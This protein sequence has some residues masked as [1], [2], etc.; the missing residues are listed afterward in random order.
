MKIAVGV[1]TDEQQRIFITQRPA[2]A[3]HAGFWEFPGGKLE[4]GEC[5]HDAL[6]RE[7]QEEI[8]I[9]VTDCVF[10]GE[11]EHRYATHAVMIY[12]YHVRDYVGSVSC[13]EQQPAFCWVK[14]EEL[15]QYLFPEA[16]HKIIDVYL[17]S[18]NGQLNDALC[19]ID[20]S[21]GDGIA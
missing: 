13:C 11:I 3:T 15:G 2:S 7:L 4:L 6:V 10:L 9:K 16:N 5:H 21:H 14:F 18:T 19:R 17:K 1:I 20:F 12:V 8:G